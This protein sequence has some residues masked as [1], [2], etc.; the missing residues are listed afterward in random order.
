MIMASLKMAAILKNDGHFESENIKFGF[1]DSNKSSNV[2]LHDLLRLSFLS[3]Y[4]SVCQKTIEGVK[5]RGQVYS[6]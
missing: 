2:L 6:R 1:L 5:K 4:I 3:D